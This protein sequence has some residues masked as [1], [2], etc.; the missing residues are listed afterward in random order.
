MSQRLAEGWR[1]LCAVA[2]V[3]VWLDY[4]LSQIRILWAFCLHRRSSACLLGPT[5][6]LSRCAGSSCHF[7][8]GGL[9]VPMEQDEGTESK[10]RGITG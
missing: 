5:C 6:H 2:A 4:E 8:R 7:Y 9:F 3:E 10:D 1:V